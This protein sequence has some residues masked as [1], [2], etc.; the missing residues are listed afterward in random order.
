MKIIIKTIISFVLCFT[1]SSCLFFSGNTREYAPE[2]A[3]HVLDKKT[4][5]AIAN[6]KIIYYTHLEKVPK[7]T[8]YTDA[9]G[10]F[11]VKAITMTPVCTFATP[12]SS[13]DFSKLPG[14]Y[15]V[16]YNSYI[17]VS[18]KSY[19]SESFLVKRGSIPC[20]TELIPKEKN[21]IFNDKSITIFLEPIHLK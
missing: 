2:I 18:V 9:N 20:N 13:H 16:N 7:N 14:E 12:P 15:L 11:T 10:L 8:A 17:E 1:M 5:K 19:K 3:G 4:G 6:A 21:I